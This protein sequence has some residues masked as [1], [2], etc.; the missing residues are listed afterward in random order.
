[1]QHFGRAMRK[2]FLRC[3]VFFAIGII[4]F[5]AIQNILVPHNDAK[6][7]MNTSGR[8]HEGL[9]ALESDSVDVLFLGT[10][11]VMFGVSPMEI[12]ERTG[13]C[14]YNLATV[15]QPLECSYYILKDAF[16]TQSK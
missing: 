9:L 10:S 12:Y 5:A 2:L 16:R 3:V 1:M 14:S 11:L 7:Y 13:I 15:A 8:V 4:L 6:V